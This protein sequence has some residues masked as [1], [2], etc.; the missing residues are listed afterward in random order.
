MSVIRILHGYSI[1]LVM[2]FRDCNAQYSEILDCRS[3]LFMPII[4]VFFIFG[5]LVYSRRSSMYA[6]SVIL[7]QTL[8]QGQLHSMQVLYYIMDFTSTDF[9]GFHPLYFTIGKKYYWLSHQVSSLN[10]I[11]NGSVFWSSGSI[12]LSADIRSVLLWHRQRIYTVEVQKC[13]SPE[14]IIQSI[15]ENYPQL[16]ISWLV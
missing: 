8:R 2:S 10:I 16:L 1:F 7:L 14:F 9:Y 15:C 5:I 12:L 6:T 13:L 3:S 4:G 11:Q